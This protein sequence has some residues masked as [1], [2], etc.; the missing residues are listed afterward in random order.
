[1]EC[2]NSQ[3]HVIDLQENNIDSNTR[4]NNVIAHGV[5]EEEDGTENIFQFCS[6]LMTEIGRV[7]PRPE[8]LDTSRIGSRKAVSEGNV[9][10]SK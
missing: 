9:A 6:Y 7:N 10:Q 1:M 2:I 8:I 5:D 3:K 4:S